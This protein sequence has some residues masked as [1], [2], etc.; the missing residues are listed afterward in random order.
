MDYTGTFDYNKQIEKR[1]FKSF[2]RLF[3]P[4]FWLVIV[5]FIVYYC[6]CIVG[7]FVEISSMQADQQRYVQK[8][9]ELD[10]EINT[11][12][13]NINKA[14][15]IDEIRYIASTELNMIK[16]D[17]K[18]AIAMTQDVVV[19]SNDQ[20]QEKELDEFSFVAAMRSIFNR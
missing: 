11:L 6:L 13:L 8:I 18:K 7:Q 5:G 1:N 19:L 20:I 12:K 9:S 17:E 15:N 14:Q 4:L 10:N 16:R 2:K 3:I